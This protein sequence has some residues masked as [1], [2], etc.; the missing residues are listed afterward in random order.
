MPKPIFAWMG[1]KSRLALAPCRGSSSYLYVRNSLKLLYLVSY[2]PI[3]NII[4]MP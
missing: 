4:V 1:G 3:S 2:S